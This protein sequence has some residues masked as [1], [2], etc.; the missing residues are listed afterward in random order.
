MRES[1][2]VGWLPE[3]LFGWSEPILRRRMRRNGARRCAKAGYGLGWLGE[4]NGQKWRNGQ[5]LCAHPTRPINATAH[6]LE[7]EEIELSN[8]ES[9]ANKAKGFKEGRQSGRGSDH[10]D[11]SDCLEKAFF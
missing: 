7:W 10:G 4:G 5:V 8:D 11:G 3:G 2:A 6:Y 9:G 1:F